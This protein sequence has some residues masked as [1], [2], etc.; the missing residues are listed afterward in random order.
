MEHSMS[1]ATFR[2]YQCKTWLKRNLWLRS[3]KW[4]YSQKKLKQWFYLNV[5][6]LKR[7]WKPK[8]GKYNAEFYS[9]DRSSL[10]WL[11][12]KTVSLRVNQMHIHFSKWIYIL[13]HILSKKKFLSQQFIWVNVNTIL[14]LD[15][16]LTHYKCNEK[17]FSER[18]QQ[19]F[20]AII[21]M[22]WLEWTPK[23]SINYFIK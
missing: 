20:E 17:V 23:E 19:Y 22:T 14:T 7:I 4:L 2:F 13:F 5:L 15:I 11:E 1:L 18:K 3:S 12:V 10:C 6:Q 16:K 9:L 8:E 21:N